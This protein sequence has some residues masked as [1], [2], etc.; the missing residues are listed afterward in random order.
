MQLLPPEVHAAR[1]AA[2]PWGGRGLAP[3]GE[4]RVVVVPSASA[5]GDKVALEVQKI[6]S[7]GACAWD[8]AVLSL[9]GQSRSK[10]A[11]AAKIGPYGVA[12][13]D[14]ADTDERIVADTFLRFKG[15]ERPWIVLGELGL[16]SRRYDV[17]M[18]VALTRALVGCVVLATREELDA[19]PRLRAMVR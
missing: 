8:V 4:L 1:G 12:R 5:L 3:I 16:G 6:I 2:E 9:A 17:R 14:A 19:D 10:L 15:L 11:V 18:H 13:A 7:G